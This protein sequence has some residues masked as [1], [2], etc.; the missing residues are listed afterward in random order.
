M[1]RF[2]KLNCLFIV[3]VLL[4]YFFIVFIQKFPLIFFVIIV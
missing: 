2:R 3:N 4:D 1:Q